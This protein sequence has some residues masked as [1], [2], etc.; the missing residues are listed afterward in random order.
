MDPEQILAEIQAQLAGR[1][2]P[3]A[4]TLKAIRTRLD[5]YA[6][7]TALKRHLQSINDPDVIL[8]PSVTEA[9]PIQILIKLQ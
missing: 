6:F 9:Y 5:D 7:L 8:L 2:S 4:A 1:P 3:D